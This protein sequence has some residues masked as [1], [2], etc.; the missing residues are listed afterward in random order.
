MAPYFR[1]HHPKEFMNRKDAMYVIR[2]ERWTSPS[3]CLLSYYR[4][5]DLLTDRHNEIGFRCVYDAPPPRPR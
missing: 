1:G 4:G 3:I 2:G 5:K